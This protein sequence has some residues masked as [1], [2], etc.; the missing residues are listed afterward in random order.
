MKLQDADVPHLLFTEQ[1]SAPATPATGKWKPF[2]KSDGLYH[3]DDAGAVVGPVVSAA[4]PTFTGLPTGPQWKSTGVTGANTTPLTISGANASGAPASGAHVKG[5]IAGDDTGK[6]WYCTVAGTPGTWVQIG[7]SGSVSDAAYGA[8]WNGD[9][10]TAPSKNAVYDKIETLSG[11]GSLLAVTNYEPGSDTVVVSSGSASSLTAI[12]TTN[13]IVTFTTTSTGNV[14][15]RLESYSIQSTS[16]AGQWGLLNASGGAT[17]AGPAGV[18]GTIG[19]NGTRYV[20][21]FNITGLTASTSYTLQWA[22]RVTGGTHNIYAGAGG[23]TSKW[24]PLSLEV[25][26][27]A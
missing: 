19:G 2:F 16:G 12:D 9:T 6:L 15:V 25:W 27:L 3:V 21:T 14:R 17:L 13:A 8:G 1:G 10:T 11:A 24:G 20:C 23:S 5:E 4:S 7:A 18:V 26:A 22:Y